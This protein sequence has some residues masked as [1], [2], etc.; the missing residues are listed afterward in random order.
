MANDL[1]PQRTGSS[2]RDFLRQACRGAAAVT[3]FAT[4]A[5]PARAA[6]NRTARRNIVLVLSDDHRYDFL[7]FLP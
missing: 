6:D 7:R 1:A 3:L 4:A 5:P 2:R